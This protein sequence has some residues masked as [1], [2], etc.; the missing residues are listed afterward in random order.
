MDYKIMFLGEAWGEEEERERTAFVGSSGKLLRGMSRQAGIEWEEVFR[1]NVF[2]LRPQPT[3][4]IKNLCGPRDEAI[5]DYPAIQRS[6][7]IRS[8]YAG[9]LSR[10]GDE[11]KRVSP[12]LIVAFGGTA[13]WALTKRPAPKITEIRGTTLQSIFGVKMLPTIH[14]S[15]VLRSWDWRPIVVMD[16][17]KAKM[18]MEFPEVRTPQR[19]VWIEPTLADLYEFEKYIDEHEYLSIDIETLKE[20]ITCIGFAPTTDLCLVVPFLDWRKPGN[21]YWP[22]KAAEVEAWKW[23]MR[24]VAKP[25]KITG[26][27]FAYD[28]LFMLRQYATPC[29]HFT[30]DTM[31]MH[32]AMQPEMKKGLGFLASIY[33]NEASWKFMRAKGTIKR[34]D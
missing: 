21:N 3:N 10:L 7:Y 9:E 15:A 2:N 4:D 23:C 25:K 19:K 8:A 20:Q 33:T 32:H 17:M 30:H 12:N 5:A 26:Q 22:T 24:Q 16:L 18:E 6:K 1:T 31:L 13:T 14:P 27:N 28:M 11:I 34:E 29:P